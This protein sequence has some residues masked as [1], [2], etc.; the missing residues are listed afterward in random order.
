MTE[1]RFPDAGRE[2]FFRSPV[3]LNRVSGRFSDGFLDQKQS[4]GLKNSSSTLVIPDNVSNGR[5]NSLVWYY[6][7]CIN[8]T[9]IKA[10]GRNARNNSGWTI[11]TWLSQYI[12]RI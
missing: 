3:I 7:K 8:G 1:D 4:Y 11:T 5:H 9:T 2:C 12:S 10:T 6:Q